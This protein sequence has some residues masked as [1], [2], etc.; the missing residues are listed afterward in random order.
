MSSITPYV[1]IYRERVVELAA[2]LFTTPTVLKWPL[3]VAINFKCGDALPRGDLLRITPDE[4]THA[5]LLGVA[6]RIRAGAKAGELQQWRRMLLSVP[7]T[8]R[9]LDSEDDKYAEVAKLRQVFM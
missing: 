1:P 6:T 5:L 7:C 8:F 2:E 3:V 4:I 9:R